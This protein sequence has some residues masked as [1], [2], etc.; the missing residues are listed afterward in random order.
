IDSAIDLG[1]Q[2][3][4]L[5][6]V[7][8]DWKIRVNSAHILNIRTW[9]ELIEVNPK[10]STRLLSGLIIHLSLCGVFIRDID[11]FPRDITRFLNSRIG[12]VY[13]LA[14]QFTR[15]CPAFYN[16]IGAEGQL[17]EISTQLDEITH[18][19]DR[20]IHFLRKQSHVESS[21]QIV[22]FMEATLHFWLTRDKTGLK[23]FVPPN[24]YEEIDDQGIYVDGVN[25][26]ISFFA[27]NGI[28]VPGDLLSL[29]DQRLK[30]LLDGS[31]AG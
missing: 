22:P 15:L 3:P 14:K 30:M 25:K 18:R 6:G 10:W 7:D 2:A 29:S 1:F 9:L 27:E 19:R 24:I 5:Q 8:N 4:M 31:K 12:P 21:N 28:R 13:N 26:V 23:P 17:R 20:L 11:I 16:D